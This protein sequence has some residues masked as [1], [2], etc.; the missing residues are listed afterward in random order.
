[1]SATPGRTWARATRSARIDITVGRPTGRT[2]RPTTLFAHWT[3]EDPAAIILAIEDP[4]VPE[5]EVVEWTVARNTLIAAHLPGL[6][7]E[8]VGLGDVK[9]RFD[10]GL[11]TVWL[12]AAEL[13][14]PGE[15]L[16]DIL[17][18]A[19][20][21]CPLGEAEA[22]IYAAMIEADLAELFGGAE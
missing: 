6:A 18:D 17:R 10:S 7:G 5:R 15:M 4:W 11:T 8:I 9:V 22:S 2:T 21:M 20:I 14:I 1:M 16:V 12:R 3:E 13:A 19:A